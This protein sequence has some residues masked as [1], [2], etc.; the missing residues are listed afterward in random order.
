MRWWVAAFVAVAVGA[1]GFARA[2]GARP[3]AGPATSAPADDV[4]KPTKGEAS[5][6]R[7]ARTETFPALFADVAADEAAQTSYRSC[8]ADIMGKGR[9]FW[10][11]WWDDLVGD[12]DLSLQECG[13]D[14]ARCLWLCLSLKGADACFTT[15]RV[16]QDN[17]EPADQGHAQALFAQSCALGYAAG[18]TNRGAGVKNGGRKTDPFPD[19]DEP[20]TAL[21]LFRSFKAA[22]DRDDAWGCTMHGMSYHYGEG[23]S[24][25]EERAKAA[26]ARACAIDPDFVACETAQEELKAM[27]E[28]ASDGEPAAR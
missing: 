22:C 5:A 2:E 17:A 11:R 3:E 20:R 10:R 14:P 7:A 28:P 15:A 27:A 25:D 4:G 24:V 13:E 19:P 18:C 21:C 1:S 23:V 12:T 6:G 26:Y 16:L 8:P 9:P